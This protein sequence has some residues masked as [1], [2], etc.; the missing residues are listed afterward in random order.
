MTSV[1]NTS[2]SALLAFQRALS[3]VSHN[4]A[5]INT[6]GYSRQVTEFATATPNRNGQGQTTGSGT[7][8]TA[9]RRV[10]DQLAIT[11]LIDSNA[12]VA[13]LQTLSDLS[14]RIDTLLS[15][16]ATNLE[17]GWSN[18]FNAVKGL[19]ADPSSLTSRQDT[20][21]MA[22]ALVQRF[23]RLDAQFE[24]LSQEVNNGL[25]SAAAEINRLTDQIAQLNRQI[26]SNPSRV[27]SDLLDR[28]DTLANDLVTLT[29]GSIHLQDGGTMNV[30]A[31]GGT[32]LV[33]GATATKVEV[34]SDPFQ[35]ERLTLALS[36][37]NLRMDLGDAGL[38]GKVGGLLEFRRE[39]LDPVQ[40]DLGRIA[41]GLAQAF[42]AQQAGGVDQYGQRGQ[43]LF[44]IGQPTTLASANNTGDAQLQLSIADLA[45]LDGQNVRLY[46]NGNQWQASNASTGE[47][48]VMTGAG[49]ADSPFLINGMAVVLNGTAAKG[50]QYLLRPTAGLAGSLGVAIT[51]PGRLAAAAPLQASS[52]LG[53]TGT[54]K[55]SGLNV[56]DAT[57]PALSTPVTLTF[58]AAGRYTLNGQ[59]PYDYTPGERLQ[60]NGWSVQ[61]D[62]QPAVGDTFSLTPTGA[63]SSDN[64]NA[65][66]L[67]AVENLRQFTGGAQ[68]LVDVMAGLTTRAGSAARGA[69]YS[70]E[71]ASVIQQQASATRESISGVNLDEEAAQMLKLQQAYQ[72]ASQMVAAADTM[73][74]SILGVAAR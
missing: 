30:Y 55:L 21:D 36:S 53:N 40:A 1:L 66:L 26:G 65:T 69:E 38:G 11:R 72:A 68:S 46:F 50:D 14:D 48:V 9:I 41:L 29:G 74:Q 4:V 16:K 12:E 70:L 44:T 56:T 22:G 67:A 7:Q 35:T 33:T 5:N 2:S 10:A 49:T 23:S 60:A 43:D 31:A 61:L 54:A 32:A 34:I 42:N 64:T 20:L 52:A 19:S 73:F 18:F 47:P 58:V 24:A 3:T 59:G 13:R 39:V 8:I 25:T 62:G 37:H 17:G 6:E 57:N 63:G 71:A 51:D 15:E 28:R 45:R 27:S